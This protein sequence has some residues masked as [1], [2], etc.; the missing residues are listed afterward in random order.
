VLTIKVAE[1]RVE[2]LTTVGHFTH[3]ERRITLGESW[4]LCH[5]GIIGWCS[6]SLPLQSH[7]HA[8]LDD[9][10]YRRVSSSLQMMCT[11]AVAQLRC[12]LA[13]SRC[14]CL[15]VRSLQHVYKLFESTSKTAPVRTHPLLQSKSVLS[16]IFRVQASLFWSVGCCQQQATRCHQ[17]CA[18]RSTHPSTTRNTVQRYSEPA[19]TARQ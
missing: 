11:L 13:D 19:A 5:F 15:P 3:Y 2:C 7:V 1:L 6:R 14:T 16:N 9:A 18:L 10:W 4:L 8:T 12:A 17:C